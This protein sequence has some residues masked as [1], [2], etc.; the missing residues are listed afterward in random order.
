MRPASQRKTK[1]VSFLVSEQDK[2]LIVNEAQKSR[3]SV[4][5]FVLQ[6]ILRSLQNS[7]AMK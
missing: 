4:S 7:E 2:N 5:S 3:L 6:I 1:L